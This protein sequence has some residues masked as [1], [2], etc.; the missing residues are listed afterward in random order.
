MTKEDDIHVFF[1]LV[2]NSIKQWPVPV[3]GLL[4]E[5]GS[6]PFKILIACILSLRTR[7]QTTAEASERLFAISSD[8]YAMSEMD[9]KE[10]EK[11]IFPVGF[12]RTKSR[13]IQALSQKISD[14]F[15]GK[16]PD[17]IEDLLCLPGVGRKTANLVLT[18]GHKKPGICVDTHVHRICNRWGYV[19]TKTPEQTEQILREKLPSKF[20]IPINGLLV[21]FGQNQ[22]TP[23][24]PRCSSCSLSGICKKV[25]LVSS[26]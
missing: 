11:A 15:A 20:W 16:T 23:I 26:R 19:V 13:Q 1:R 4:A 6:D 25:G 2:E 24:S 9:L 12:F 22:C 14:D 21:S 7:D 8:P 5:Q 18:L 3:V 10:I 17:T